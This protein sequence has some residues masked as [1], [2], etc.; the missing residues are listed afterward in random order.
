MRKVL[1]PISTLLLSAPLVG[2]AA[3]MS[4]GEKG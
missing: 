1:I 3:A 2:P 4:E